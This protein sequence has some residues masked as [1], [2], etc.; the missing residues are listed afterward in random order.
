MILK[1]L[2][3]LILFVAIL[4]GLT[5]PVFAEVE[6][7]E[8]VV[9]QI[10]LTDEQKAE[11]DVIYKSMLEQTKLLANKYEEFGVITPEKKEKWVA[12]MERHYDHI[13]ESGYIMSWDKHKHHKHKR[14][15]EE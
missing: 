8:D 14:H 6:A 10:T 3:S 1:K 11:L 2:I 12:K 15:H 5:S 13:K 4:G 7:D 9:K